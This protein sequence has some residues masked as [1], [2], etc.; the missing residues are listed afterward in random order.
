[1]RNDSSKRSKL[2][3][4]GR[5]HSFI[6]LPHYILRSTEFNSLNGN[7]VK[8]LLFLA[9]Q[10]NGRNNGNLSM[11]KVDLVKAG[12]SSEATAR[13][14]RDE[15]CK[16][17]FIRITRHGGS[18]RCYLFAIT[19]LPVDECEGKGLEVSSERVPCHWW[20]TDSEV[21]KRVDTT[22]KTSA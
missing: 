17:Q 22:L 8:L 12:W 11:A 2:K 16:K 9:A 7:A 13:R 3:G 19:W 10:F 1:M 6:Q 14:A 5:D 21:P 15:L 4:R 20:K 18:R